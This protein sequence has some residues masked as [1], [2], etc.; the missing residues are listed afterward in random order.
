MKI[1][2]IILLLFMTIQLSAQS[3]IEDNWMLEDESTI[4]KIYKKN[5]SYFGKI[6]WLEE[7]NDK[8]GK[9]YLDVENPDASK[10]GQALTG[11]VILS[12]Y[13]YKDN[14]W[15]NGEIYDP[16]EGETYK[17]KMWLSDYNTLKL[18]GYWGIFSETTTWKRKKGKSTHK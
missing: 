14:E 12:D 17:G 16:E 2:N 3:K 7:P 9:P 4:I 10:R 1:L 15:M 18:K 6:I 5:N 13:I 8:Q 11:L